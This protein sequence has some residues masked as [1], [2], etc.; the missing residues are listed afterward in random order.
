MARQTY[1]CGFLFDRSFENV[2]LIRKNRPEKQKGR[3]NGVGGKVEEGGDVP[4][5]D[6]ERVP[7]GSWHHHQ[8]R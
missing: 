4:A 5:G 6:G 7:R 2:L 8:R 3:L 1:V